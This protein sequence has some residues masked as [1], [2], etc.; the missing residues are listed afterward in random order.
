MEPI[1]EVS[2]KRLATKREKSEQEIKER[3]DKFER[4]LREYDELVEEFKDKE[5]MTHP[6]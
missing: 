4:T 2:E 1:F 5:V 3:R 6:Q